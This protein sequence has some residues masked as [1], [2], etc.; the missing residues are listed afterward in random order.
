[1]EQGGTGE[2]GDLSAKY[3]WGPL[4]G[5]PSVTNFKYYYHHHHQALLPPPKKHPTATAAAAAPNRQRALNKLPT[6]L[7]RRNFVDKH[8]LSMR[9]GT[10]ACKNVRA[11]C[12]Y[13]D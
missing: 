7:R 12:A 10:Q 5:G 9:I 13:S 8:R 2:G 11:T 4:Q 3:V 6:E 1:M